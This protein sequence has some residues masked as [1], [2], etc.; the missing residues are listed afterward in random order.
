MVVALWHSVVVAE[1]S[2][3]EVTARHNTSVGEPGPWSGYLT[4]VAALGAALEEVTAAGGV[5]D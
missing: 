5:G 1:L 3:F 4:T 2:V